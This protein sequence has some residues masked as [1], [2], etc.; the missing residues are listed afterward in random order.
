MKTKRN[1][2]EQCDSKH[3][4]LILK[5]PASF[6]GAQ[7]RDA[8]P[9]GNGLIGASVYGGV[10]RERI[11][12]NHGDLWWC[13][14][15]P[16]MPD[17]SDRLPETRRLLLEG[18]AP[19][20]DRVM[21]DA[22]I[23]RGYHPEMGCPLPVG[24]LL[25]TQPAKRGFK[26][27]QRELD[28]ESGEIK[29]SWLD[30][31]TR[32]ERALFVSRTADWVVC[33]LR[34]EG[35][36]PINATITL[37]L[38][39]RAD[40]RKPF[41]W[42]S[43][44]LPQ[45]VEVHAENDCIYYASAA[46]AVSADFGAVARIIVN[47]G[48]LETG[49]QGIHV[50]THQ[51][52]LIVLKIFIQEERHMAWTHLG[53]ELHKFQGNYPSLFVLH[54]DEHRRLFQAVMLNLGAESCQRSNEELL[55]EAYNGEASLELVEKMWAY[56]RYLLISSS[57]PGG[58]LCSLLGLW[59]GEY[60]GFFAFNMVNVNMQMIYWQAFSGNM[61]EVAL[62]VFDY[63]D[64]MM[65]DFRTNAQRLFGCRGI[66]VPAPTAPDS[67]LLKTLAPHIIHWTGGGGWIAQH[68][69]DYYLYTG[70]EVF[71]RERALPFMRE[72]ALFYQDFW[73]LGNDGYW[74]IC[75]SNS[76][77]NS[78]GNY[79]K[80]EGKPEM[81]TTI[82]ATMDFAIAKELLTHLVEGAQTTGL[83]S[84]EIPTWKAMLEH[85]P[86]YQV[87]EDGAVKEW[88][89]P[90]FT[91]NYHHR[92]QSHLYP[93][94]PG[95]EVTQESDPTLFQAF[96]TAVKKRL[97]IGL[98]EQSGWGLTYMANN[99]A[100]M[101]EGDLALECLDLL[102]R[103]CL[104]NNFFTTHNDWRDMGICVDLPWAPFQIDANMGWTGAVQEM[105]VFST[106]GFMRILPA[107]PRRWEKGSVTGLLCRGGVRV[108]ISWD[109]PEKRIGA[110]LS[111]Q[112]SQTVKVKFPLAIQSAR[113]NGKPAA[114]SADGK[115]IVVALEKGVKCCLEA[116]ELRVL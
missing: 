115:T 83:Y 55:L 21:A 112:K 57:R 4:K 28:L 68:Y 35:P 51:S 103:S 25:I 14:Q 49:D 107:L 20:A 91:D 82:N 108:D 81:E 37:D 99:Y 38:H 44:P 24:D 111:A 2:A 54:A 29:V 15:N 67:G 78:P 92:H 11:L 64:R 33:E 86:P 32:F 18:R 58:N 76:P 100:R 26:E 90:F 61:P 31:E 77:E 30:G 8:L 104:L 75:P 89:H 73:I 74:L 116:A 105:L 7:W 10:H 101:G 48:K 110:E 39:D 9:A 5:T 88:M 72:V 94:F 70:D 79:W 40:V 69:Y 98:K 87:N 65:K 41:G 95:T 114:V 63:H 102:S 17:V 52:V 113:I 22:L 106:V 46:D 42:P 71:L 47:D 50:E 59:C 16:E 96:V 34:C 93:V 109:V 1:S 56:G 43:S 3:M 97:V 80:G 62:P 66:F 84:E 85:I 23:E 12:L 27:Y 53:D 36:D 13:S 60:Q 45:R 19:E 6:F